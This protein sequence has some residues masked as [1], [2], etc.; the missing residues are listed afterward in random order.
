MAG[1]LGRQRWP[2]KT[3][4]ACV[5]S[6]YRRIVYG[7][8]DRCKGPWVDIFLD[9]ELIRIYPLSLCYI[10]DNKGEGYDESEAVRID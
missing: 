8:I 5:D 9:A 7:K 1:V 10:L 3:F 4:D 6:N 2:Y